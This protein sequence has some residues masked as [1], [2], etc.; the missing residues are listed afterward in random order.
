MG[1]TIK[2]DIT[3]HVVA[4]F[5]ADYLEL[6]TSKFM[7]GKFYVNNEEKQYVLEDGYVHEGGKF[8]RIIDTHRG[9][10]LVAESCDLGWCSNDSR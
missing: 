4:K 7:I 3:N 6:Y 1:R 9:N 2:I 8:Y 10:Q 5:K